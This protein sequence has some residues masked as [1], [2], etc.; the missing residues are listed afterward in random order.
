MSTWRVAVAAPHHEATAAARQAVQSGGNALDAALAAAAVLT[1]VYPHQCAL[2]G[3]LI[4]VVRE[5]DGSVHAV[6]SV[7]AAAS[8]IDVAAIRAAHDRMPGRGPLAVTVPGVVAG[9]RTLE[10]LGAALPLSSA[11]AEA[12]RI[13]EEGTAVSAGMR[14]AL[15]ANAE[16]LHTDPGSRAAFFDADGQPLAEGALWRQPAL[17][18]TLRT[19]ADEPSAFYTGDL[20]AT[21]VAGLQKLGSPITAGDLAVHRAV[22]TTPVSRTIDGVRWFTAPAPSQASALLAV[23]GDD[24]RRSAADLLDRSI[25]V[26]QARDALLADP[27]VAEVDLDRFFAAAEGTDV[28]A[29][30]TGPGVPRPQGDT[31]AVT[32]VDD[33]GRAVTLIQS[34]YQ[35]FGAGLLEPETGIVL[36]SRGSAFSLDPG[37]PAFL[38]PG[39]RPPHTLSP[40]V[41]VGDDLVLALGCQGGRAQPWILS[42]VAGDLTDPGSDAVEVLGRQRWVFGAR[43]IGADEPTLVVEHDGVADDLAEVAARAGLRSTARGARW[44]EAGHVQVSRLAGG[45]LSTASDPRADGAAEIVTGPVA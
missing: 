16:L 30:L 44:D 9:W 45:N 36:H 15:L 40:T 13:A 39:A 20:A 31:V 22:T 26:A 32:A 14:R 34:V 23:L 42:Q 17:A 19:L 11:L 37:H 8:G 28:F 5:P 6:V 3:D 41:A 38:R 33:E 7:G 12:A 10:G 29:A 1:V 4:A 35:S 2:G 21:L 43:D 27:R 25:R 24:A 18:R